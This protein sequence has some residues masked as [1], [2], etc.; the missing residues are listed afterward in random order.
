MLFKAQLCVSSSFII[1]VHVVSSSSPSDMFVGLS[2]KDIKIL[3]AEMNDL[4]LP[5]WIVEPGD[6]NQRS[7]GEEWEK[8]RQR[9]IQWLN[10]GEREG[11]ASY[12]TAVWK[13]WPT[14][15]C[16]TLQEMASPGKRERQT[17]PMAAEGAVENQRRSEWSFLCQIMLGI[18][19][20]SSFKEQIKSLL[21]SS[22]YFKANGVCFDW[23]LRGCGWTIEGAKRTSSWR[24]DNFTCF[25]SQRAN[26][27]DR[28][29]HTPSPHTWSCCMQDLRFT[30]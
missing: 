18:F 23:Y 25:Y 11:E 10:K 24:K 26:H 29:P 30:M 16:L 27:Q 9:R 5:N 7:R 2:V 17:R 12:F 21:E 20:I 13:I 22:N 19:Q 3:R 6:E 4:L 8:G 1:V 14:W 28:S 15:A